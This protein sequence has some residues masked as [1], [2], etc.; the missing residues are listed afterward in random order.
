MQNGLRYRA[1]RGRADQ[2]RPGP[3]RVSQV[4]MR[5]PDFI[6]RRETTGRF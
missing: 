1:D 2:L 4:S 3:G 6:M 5:T